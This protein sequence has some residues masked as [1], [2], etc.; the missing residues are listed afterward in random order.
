MQ[1]Q[2]QA[3]EK[4]DRYIRARY[5]IIGV[6]SHEESRVLAAVDAIANRRTRSMATWA[7]TTGLQNCQGVDQD[8]TRD[9]I[10]VLEAIA[11][12][13]SESDPVIF[14]LKDLHAYLTDPLVIR[15]LRDIAARFEVGRHTLI[16]LAPA[17]K[18][19]TEL[20]KTLVVMDWPL[21]DTDEL[22]AI[23]N[24]C[25]TDLPARIPVTL[26]GSRESVVQAMRGLTAFE[27]GSVLL[28]AIAA[29]GEL[30][31]EVIPY[32]ITEKRQ[33]IRKSG[34]LEIYESNLTMSDVGGLSH[35]KAYASRMRAAFSAEAAAEGVDTPKGIL[36]VGVPGTGKSLAAKAIAGG[37]MPLLRLDFGSIMGGLV[38]ESESNIREA[39]K[40]AEAISPCVLWVDEIEKA[41]GGVESSNRTDGGTMTRVFGTLL[42]WMQEK[43]SPVYIVAT[44][45]DVRSLRSEFLRA[46]RFD[47]MFWVDL[48]CKADRVEV[49]SVHL[50]KRK[51]S[52]ADFDLDAVADATWGYTGAEIEQIVKVAISTAFY[53][54]TALT[55]AHLVNAVAEIVP[56]AQTMQEAVADLRQWGS[57]KAK[58]ANHPL[59]PKP[60]QRALANRTDDL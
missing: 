33:I 3:I 4:L 27:A 35:L 12:Y 19:P 5:P 57:Q 17:I 13:S 48:P 10:P 9:P 52:P 60:V 15:Y 1:T 43:T 29:T 7:I 46:G 31:D 41:L 32:I 59:E 53:Q 30:G 42:T 25:E 28:N 6:I 21:P 11:N 16:L 36:L 38:G 54:R 51:K 55:T 18:V 40:V 8:A 58:A 14:V 26:N 37:H 39:I 24:K 47:D 22:A 45:N 50:A 56:I 23:L 2:T 49:L 44:A 20:D 34:A